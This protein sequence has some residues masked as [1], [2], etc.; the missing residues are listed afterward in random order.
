MARNLPQL[1]TDLQSVSAYDHAAGDVRLIQ[2]HISYVLLAGEF[3]YKIKKPLDLGFL[4]YSTLELRRRMCE[5]EVR[6]N[7]RLC[8]GLYL[9][10]VP[11]T[12]R[13]DGT[14]RVGGVGEPVEYAVRSDAHPAVVVQRGHH[15]II[16]TVEEAKR[17]LRGRREKIGDGRRERHL[18]GNIFQYD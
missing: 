17:Q 2:T 14:H 12:R 18:G 1:V 4:D 5:D 13:A 16:S 11:I 7:R 10:V 6:L 3:A 8:D 15:G 9:G